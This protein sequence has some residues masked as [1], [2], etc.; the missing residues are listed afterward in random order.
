[1]IIFLVI[2]ILVVLT[3]YFLRHQAEEKLDFHKKKK[4]GKLPVYL[5]KLHN[6]G[7]ADSRLQNRPILVKAIGVS[8]MVLLAGITLASCILRGRRGIKIALALVFGGGLANLAERF[9]HGYVTDYVQF[10]TPFPRLNH[11][12]FNL[13]DFCIFIGAVAAVLIELCH[14]TGE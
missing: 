11:L 8:V 12:V 1:M 14:S 3:E 4:I 13:A 7:M 10:R 6:Y 2:L 5:R 9:C